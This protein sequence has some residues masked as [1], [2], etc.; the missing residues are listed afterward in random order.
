MLC[1]ATKPLWYARKG[2]VNGKSHD[3]LLFLDVWKTQSVAFVDEQVFGCILI[4][5]ISEVIHLPSA[6]LIRSAR[7]ESCWLVPWMVPRSRRSECRKGTF[8]RCLNPTFLADLL[9]ILTRMQRHPARSARAPRFQ[10]DTVLLG[11][12]PADPVQTRSVAPS[13]GSSV[14]D[15]W[16]IPKFLAHHRTILLV[17]GSNAFHDTVYLAPWK[18]PLDQL[19]DP[20]DMGIQIGAL[21][22]KGSLAAGV[23]AANP[24]T[25]RSPSNNHERGLR[26]IAGPLRHHVVVDL[27]DVRDCY[28]L[29]EVRGYHSLCSLG[30]LNTDVSQDL[31]SQEVTADTQSRYAIKKSNA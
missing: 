5:W 25:R 24:L 16:L 22:L 1:G 9:Q 10:A 30:L 17:H 31:Q 7:L 6:H 20:F 18:L 19:P 13:Q 3:V 27:L 21:V 28:A 14:T 23:Q 29:R 26:K 8:G 15:P 11:Q 12:F 4:G 2:I